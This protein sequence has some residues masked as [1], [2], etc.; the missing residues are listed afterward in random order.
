MASPCELIAAQMGKLFTCEPINYHPYIRIRTPFLYPDGD[1]ID[2]FYKDNE[3]TITLTDLGETLGWLKMQTI[4]QQ[5]SLKQR[6]IIA[7]IC[8][9]HNVEFHQGMFSIQVKHAEDLASSVIRFSQG[10]SRVSDLWFTFRGKVGESIV[11]EVAELFQDHSIQFERRP[12]I[13]GRSTTIWYPDFRIGRKTSQTLIKV[14]ST[15]SHAASHS[16]AINVAAMWHDLSDLAKGREASHF[17]SL[18]DDTVNVWNQKD[19]LLVQN[20]SDAAY[21]SRPD[22]FLQKI[23]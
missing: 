11:D 22:E 17:I 12:K 8:L 20:E 16:I 19:I 15:G 7:D 4:A 23:A 18:F 14:L 21:W 3:D 1:M 9:T 13:Q 6:Q 5:L 10:L 2:I